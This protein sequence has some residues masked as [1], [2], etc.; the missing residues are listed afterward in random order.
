MCLV[1]V[2]KVYKWECE[3]YI[4]FCHIIKKDC[5]EITSKQPSDNN[6]KIV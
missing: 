1:R 2:P 3:K 6:M 4:S 5:L